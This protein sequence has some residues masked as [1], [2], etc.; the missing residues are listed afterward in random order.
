MLINVLPTYSKWF[1]FLVYLAELLVILNLFNLDNNAYSILMIKLSVVLGAIL[2]VSF[3]LETIIRIITKTDHSK[4]D[5]LLYN[6][7]NQFPKWYRGILYSVL[8][9]VVIFLGLTFT[10]TQPS[11]IWEFNEYY[12]GLYS[13]FYI[14]GGIYLLL[15]PTSK[16]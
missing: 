6:M 4:E 9:F 11:W 7:D 16:N 15:R 13:L 5:P 12:L 8:V 1:H 3:I 10:N 14:A 2:I